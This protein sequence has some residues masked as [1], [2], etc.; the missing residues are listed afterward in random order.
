MM[1]RKLLVG[2]VVALAVL[3]GLSWFTKRER[4]STTEGGGFE[5]LLEKPVDA[6]Q[7]ATIRAWLG[8]APDSTVELTR[9][10]DGW[11]VSSA[12]GWPAKPDLVTRLLE[13]LSGLKGERR[14]S[15]ADVLADYQIDD[16]NGVHVVGL[17]TGGTELFH[18]VVGKTASRGGSFVRKNGS[19][20]VLLTGASLRSSFGV[21]GDEPKP[22]EAKRWLE[23][24]V[25]QAER[26]EIDR[27]TLH[28]G[29][30]TIELVKEFAAAAP[31]TAAEGDSA[32]PAVDR[33]Q[34][35]W[36]DGSGNEVDKGKADG[37]LGTICNLYASDAVSP[38]DP[39]DV[40]GLAQP[41]RSVEVSFHDG[42]TETLY[43]GNNGPEDKKTYAKVG[44]DGLP[45]L[46]Y[47]ATVDRLFPERSTLKP[48]AK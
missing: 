36:K 42:R 13:D 47:K 7:V 32:A 8:S 11:V 21:W 37:I 31:D 18:I 40:Y 43:F 29:D 48:A 46:I 41:K 27:I 23:L 28:G 14:S 35:T 22:P 1:N 38:A 2:L 3:A 15:S 9:A 26:Q 10:G 16:G 12:Y 5:E 25:H 33:T 24:R 4:Y 44:E 6:G 39:D 17:G 30:G 19:D 34:W 45:A 20:D